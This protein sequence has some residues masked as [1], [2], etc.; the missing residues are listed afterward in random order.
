[1]EATGGYMSEILRV[2]VSVQSTGTRQYL[3]AG[4]LCAG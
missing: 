4:A 3:Q 1:M 2:R